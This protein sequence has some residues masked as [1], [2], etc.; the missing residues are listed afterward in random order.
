MN[1]MA[2]KT[3]LGLGT[4]QFGMTYGVANKSGQV[5]GSELKD[6]MA[7]ANRNGIKLFDTAPGYGQ[8]EQALSEYHAHFDN[9]RLITKTPHFL[10]PELL[11]D[12][13]K[14][15]F[16]SLDQSLQNLQVNTVHGLLVHRGADLLKPGADRLWAVMEDLKAAQKVRLLGVSVYSPTELLRL[17]DEFPIDIVQ[18]PLNLLDQ[19]FVQCGLLRQL[20]EASIEVH[21]RSVFLQGVLVTEPGKLPHYFKELIA[22]L[23]SLRREADDIGCSMLSM[24]LNYALRM[25]AVDTVLVGVDSAC[26]LKQILDSVKA[27]ISDDFDWKRWSVDDLRWLD[28]NQWSLG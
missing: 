4:A 16:E 1:S 8:S 13:S 11:V 25:D 12:D 3:K 10:S 18:L 19:R 24:A 28:P 15:L 9:V 27:P 5:S 7:V 26:Q 20:S 21:V 22:H 23:S 6:V 2:L 17:L 14:M